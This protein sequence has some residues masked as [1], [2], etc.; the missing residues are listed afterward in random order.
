VDYR[1]Q[2]FYY[3]DLGES[4]VWHQF[5]GDIDAALIPE[6]LFL[7]VGA[8]RYQSIID[9][10]ASIPQGNLPFSSNRANRDEAFVAPRFE[11]A[12]GRSVT[13]Q[14][15]YR[16]SWIKYDEANIDNI[17]QQEAA[18]FSIENYRRG[19]GITWAARY[20]WRKTEYD[21]FDPWEYQLAIGELGYW[22]GNNTRVFVAGG[23]ESAWD[24]PLDPGLEDSLWEAGFAQQIGT[25][26]SAEFAA[27]ERSFGSS[28]RGNAR[29]PER[30]PGSPWK[31]AKVY[32]QTFSMEFEF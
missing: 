31:R 19:R 26:L 13:M 17:D 11:F 32:L 8:T 23:K 2:A 5:D 9:P 12:L 21:N 29:Q 10:D 18:N 30:L 27:G 28:L 22:V 24:M 14:G 20:R 1:L 4:E 16:I 25:T 3:D 7:N 15:D 6:N